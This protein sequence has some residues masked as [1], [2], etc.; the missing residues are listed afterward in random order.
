MV[1]VTQTKVVVKNSKD[2][3][4]VRGNCMAAVVASLLNLTIDSVP[5][6]ETLF[7]IEGGYWQEVLM[8][9]CKSVGYDWGTDDRFRVFHDDLYGSSDGIR[10]E[11]FEQCS[12]KHYIISG[13]SPRG[14]F[15]VCIYLN[16]EMVWDPHPSREGLVTE[17]YFE[18]ILKFN[19]P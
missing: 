7:H 5:N 6:V 8:T 3:M 14:V 12:N 4:V 19:T 15:H 16:G 18:S 17:E 13:K 9:F 1:P 11:L 10:E 2:E